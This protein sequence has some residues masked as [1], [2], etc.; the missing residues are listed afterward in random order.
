M[1][2]VGVPERRRARREDEPRSQ[3]HR[4]DEQ[5]PPRTEAVDRRT[6]QPSEPNSATVV[7]EKMPAVAPRPARR[8][9]LMGRR[10]AP[11]E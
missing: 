9:S 2:D 3:R 10:K 11:K 6:G 1:S 4:S 7:T 5:H 8:S